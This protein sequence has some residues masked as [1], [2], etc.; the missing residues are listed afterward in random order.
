MQMKRII[1]KTVVLLAMVLALT[2]AANAD[3]LAGKFG[4]AS[5]ADWQSSWIDLSEAT[6][7]GQGDK[8][9][10]TLRG[11]AENIVLRLLPSGAH[12]SSSDGIVGGVRQMPRNGVLEIQLSEERHDVVQ[13]SVHGGQK[14]WNIS[15]GS[16]NGPVTLVGVERIP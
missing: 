2:T 14:A 6:N 12:P 10:I 4:S 3:K 8:L 1:T 9:R 11:S 16:Q 13:I 5:G 7:F 15:L